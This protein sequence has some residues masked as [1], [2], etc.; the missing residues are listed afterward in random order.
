MIGLCTSCGSECDDLR[1]K[2]SGLAGLVK[3]HG[4]FH[5]TVPECSKSL[6]QVYLDC[7]LAAGMIKRVSGHR[8]RSSFES[9]WGYWGVVGPNWDKLLLSIARLH[10]LLGSPPWNQERPSI[11]ALQTFAS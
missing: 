10:S 5:H 11:D 7:L 9:Y 2:I 1:D 6:A 4:A 3:Q 8:R